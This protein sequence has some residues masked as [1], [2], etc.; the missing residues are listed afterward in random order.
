MTKLFTCAFIVLGV[1]LIGV[2]LGIILSYAA[3]LN[4]R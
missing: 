2:C 1:T 4:D 3:D